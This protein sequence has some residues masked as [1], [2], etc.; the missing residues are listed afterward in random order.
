MVM[1]VMP[2]MVMVTRVLDSHDDLGVRRDWC[3]AAE[4][5]KSKQEIFHILSPTYSTV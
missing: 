5:N 3:H 4:E 1:I 2:I